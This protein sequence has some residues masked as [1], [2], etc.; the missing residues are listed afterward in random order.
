M[1]FHELAFIHGYIV[2]DI[3]SQQFDRWTVIRQAS[4]PFD[5]LRSPSIPRRAL[6]DQIQSR[7]KKLRS[8]LMAIGCV[9]QVLWVEARLSRLGG[10]AT[11]HC[12][13]EDQKRMRRI[14]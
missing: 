2:I 12:P 6:H 10:V 11:R 4:P 8:N 14:L 9:P 1:G 5:Q 13:E 3:C 7:L